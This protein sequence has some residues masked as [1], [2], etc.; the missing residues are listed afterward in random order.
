MGIDKV[1]RLFSPLIEKEKGRYINLSSEY[2]TY[3]VVPVNA[4]YTISK[5]AL[6]S[7]SNDFRRVLKYI[8]IPVVTIRPGAVKI[9]MENSTSTIFK[10]NT[11][12][13]T[14]YKGVL[15]KMG[16]LLEGGTKNAKDPKVMARV[17]VKAIEAKKPKRVYKS[18]HN[19]GVKIMSYLPQKMVDNIFYL[20]FK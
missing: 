8:G 19:L 3:Q 12:K 7:Y 16:P 6:E 20:M 11:E 15:K 4:F 9:E 17:V 14:H 13:S 10:A 2:G 5:H 18:N 1:N